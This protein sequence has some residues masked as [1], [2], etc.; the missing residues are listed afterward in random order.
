MEGCG[1]IADNALLLGTRTLQGA[2]GHTTRNKKLLGDPGIA[3]RSK[4]ATSW[5]TRRKLAK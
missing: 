1:E 5:V 2:P 4:N 3:A